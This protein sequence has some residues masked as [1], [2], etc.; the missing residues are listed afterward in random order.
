MEEVNNQSST[1]RNI[2][3]IRSEFKFL[4]DSTRPN[5]TV[6]TARGI[7]KTVASLQLAI[8]RTLELDSD[9]V[10][11][12]F[13]STTLKQVKLVVEPKMRMLLSRLGI[14]YKY[15]STMGKY[16]FSI[17]NAV[18]EMVLSSYEKPENSRGFHPHTVILDECS[19]MPANMYGEIIAPMFANHG[20]K[21]KL[22]AI[23]TPK[24][25]NKFYEF[26]KKGTDKEYP[27]WGSYMIKASDTKLIDANFLIDVR[28]NLTESE[29][30]QEFECDFDANVLV[31]SVYGE[32]M[33]RYTDQHIREEYIWDPSIP[34]YTSW[35]LGYSDY[36]AIWFFQVKGD[37]VTFI[38]YFEDDGHDVSYYADVLN[39]KPYSYG[40]CILPQDG[41]NRTLAGIS[42]S[43]QLRKFGLRCDVVSFQ[44]E[45]YGIDKARILL[46]TARFS[47]NEA[48]LLGLN[49]LRSFKY[50]IDRC[51]GMKLN[52]TLHDEHSHCA[53]AFRYAAVSDNI[54]KTFE[55]CGKVVTTKLDYNVLY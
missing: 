15:N 37:Q 31:G 23:G 26:F 30:R 17:G 14:K 24:G 55:A 16:S 49:H 36:T 52:S 42:I 21:H 12:I 29:Y 41:G 33:R 51:S 19:M 34:V 54:W 7:G 47:K 44:G 13:F 28:N 48:C 10:S 8:K 43:D 5:L 11:C 38:D 35:D 39:K 32:F 9:D 46:K 4:F 40:R 27:D 3:T 6:V 45:G 53:D 50:K 2:P 20:G 22:I 18:R 1:E 25:K